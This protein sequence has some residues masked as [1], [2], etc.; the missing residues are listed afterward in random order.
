MLQISNIQM[1]KIVTF[2][3]FYCWLIGGLVFAKKMRA[4][5]Y[6]TMLDPFYQKYGITMVVPIYLAALCGDV[7]W[8]ASIL[9]ALG[10][11]K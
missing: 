9:M 3:I 2:G 1:H 7:L 11:S 6:L 10:K 8:S 4:C 5:K